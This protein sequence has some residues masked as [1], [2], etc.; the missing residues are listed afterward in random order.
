MMIK[1]NF[2]NNHTQRQPDNTWALNKPQPHRTVKNKEKSRL[3]QKRKDTAWEFGRAGGAC[4]R[5]GG[6]RGSADDRPADAARIPAAAVEPLACTRPYDTRLC[7]RDYLTATYVHTG[8]ALD[9]SDIGLQW[10]PKL[11]F[12]VINLGSQW[13]TVGF[14]CNIRRF[15]LKCAIL[16]GEVLSDVIWSSSNKVKREKPHVLSDQGSDKQLPLWESKIRTKAMLRE[17][18][19]KKARRRAA[20]RRPRLVVRWQLTRLRKII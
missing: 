1:I 6:A 9:Y 4:A 12:W 11:D 16:F 8:R 14:K 10:L 19:R 20:D 7:P 3:Y 13:E 15:G 17:A 2:W 18:A 5:R